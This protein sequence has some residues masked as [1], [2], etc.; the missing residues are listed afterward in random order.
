ML[1][2]L[3]GA[4][5]CSLP[6]G[7]FNCVLAFPFSFLIGYTG[8]TRSGSNRRSNSK[9]KSMYC[10]LRFQWYFVLHQDTEQQRGD[11]WK[12]FCKGCF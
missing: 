10:S 2:L 12:L 3:L 1:L 11:R 5:Y 9:G 6:W 4:S 8:F 7:T